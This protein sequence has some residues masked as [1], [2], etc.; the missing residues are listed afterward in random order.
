ME[1]HSALLE[2]W[3]L[4]V[5]EMVQ[6]DFHFFVSQKV[7][8]KLTAI[9]EEKISII[10]KV[11]KNDFSLFDV[12]VVNTLHRNFDDY[13]KL[14]T[15][16]PVLCLVHNLNFSLFLKSIS[17]KNIF[18]EKEKFTYFLKL[19][20]KEKVG[21]KRKIVHLAKNFGVL[22]A[23][24]LET[25]KKDG[26]FSKKSQLIQMN[27][28]QNFEFPSEEIIQIVMPGNVSNK[29]K[30]VDLLFA[31]L[32][33]LNPKSKIHFT[34]LGKPE[35]DSV[36][37]QLENLKS[38]CHSKISITH[39]NS[40]IPWQDYSQIISKAHLLLCPI[41]SETSFYWVDEVY[42]NTKV[43]GAEADCIFNGKIGIFPST[44]PRMDWY[45]L[46]YENGS[47]LK[48]IIEDLELENIKKEYKNLNP[49]LEKY[50]FEKVKSELEEILK[51]I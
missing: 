23:S 1:T 7:N 51:N 13:K 40:F 14:F 45:N 19:Y 50:T 26:S 34:F 5:K 33:K 8:E 35:N 25:I 4:L 31:M 43:S 2:Q 47:D 38:L 18:K 16:K 17:W 49:Y 15:E 42:G 20:V 39:F 3:Y 41:K 46:Y 24:A 30:D 44:Y 11:S 12:V 48:A 36:L 37:Q 10:K 27:Y 29:R 6:I 22:S 32:P 21:S 9:P 28:C